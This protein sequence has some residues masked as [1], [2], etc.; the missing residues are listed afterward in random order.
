MCW[1]A[2]PP[3]S[4]GGAQWELG[5]WP[6]AEASEWGLHAGATLPCTGFGE[7]WQPAQ[8]IQTQPRRGARWH[9][10]AWLLK[11]ALCGRGS[12][13]QCGPLREKATG[14]WSLMS[15]P[16]S[17]HLQGPI[18]CLM[19]ATHS[20]VPHGLLV[21]GP[22]TRC[23]LSASPARLPGCQALAPSGHWSSEP[24]TPASG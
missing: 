22:C 19:S 5:P 7:A 24:H 21:T 23:L 10:Q 4:M 2:G 3:H 12:P 15:L 17:A 1:L 13:V 8:W 9:R 14:P 18:I 16:A 20:V 11:H 6:R